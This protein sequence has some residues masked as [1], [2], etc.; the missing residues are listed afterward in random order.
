MTCYWIAD[1]PPTNVPPPD[2]VNASVRHTSEPKSCDTNFLVIDIEL[3]Y[4]FIAIRK[5][6]CDNAAFLFKYI[7]TL[8]THIVSLTISQKR[9]DTHTYHVQVY[10][11]TF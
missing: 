9:Y 7:D 8:N 11:Y 5:R 2:D 4:C 10:M 1:P 6:R 3:F